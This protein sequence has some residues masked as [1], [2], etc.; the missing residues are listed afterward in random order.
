MKYRN[1]SKKKVSTEKKELEIIKNDERS[2]H[3]FTVA[4]FSEKSFKNND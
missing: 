1:L 3:D 4:G 2:V